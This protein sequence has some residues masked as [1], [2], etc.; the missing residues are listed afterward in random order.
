MDLKMD[1][2][3]ILVCGASSG[4]GHKIAKKIVSEGGIP[5]L[6]ARSEQKLQEFKSEYP[7]SEYLVADHF[8]VHGVETV[9]AKVGT[10]NWLG[11][12]INS[13]VTHSRSFCSLV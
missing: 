7:A 3:K 9:M 13:G 10:D 12:L 11:V 4:F 5:I 1:N 8:G 2:Q 6:V